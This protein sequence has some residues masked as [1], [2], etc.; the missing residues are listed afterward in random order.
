MK[1]FKYWRMPPGVVWAFLGFLTATLG[2]QPIAVIDR[3]SRQEVA[4]FETAAYLALLAAKRIPETEEPA[5]AAQLALEAGW[6][7][8][9]A[10]VGQPLQAGTWALMLM[11]ALGT[12]G[13]LMYRLVGGEWYAFKEARVRG[14]FPAHFSANRVLRGREALQ[15]LH[16]ALRAGEQGGGEP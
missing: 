2:A 15:A 9:P 10:S 1:F 12:E 5:K 7:L 8:N 13:G 16:E 11:R 4:D 14:W 6:G 3:Y